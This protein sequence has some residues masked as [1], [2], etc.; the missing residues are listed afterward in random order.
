M[1]KPMITPKL[2][3]FD[4]DGV[5][6]LPSR[7]REQV[8]RACEVYGTI[9]NDDILKGFRRNAGLSAPGK[10]MRGWCAETSSVIFGQLLSGMARMS[11]ATG[12]RALREKAVA[13]LE[14]WTE[15]LRP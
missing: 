10:D 7:V 3:S 1:E 4:Y 6:L 5:R 9:P 11:R 13:L 2:Q 8:E 15:T 14:G 12:D